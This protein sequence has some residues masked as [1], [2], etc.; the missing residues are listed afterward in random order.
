MD[1]NRAVISPNLRRWLYRGK[2]PGSIAKFVNRAWAAVVSSGVAGDLYVTLEVAG[3]KSGKIVSLPLVV[4]V[5][6]GQRYL[7]SMLG[8]DVQW[9]KNVRAASG[10]V[11]L[12]H[13]RREAV[14]LEDV[15]VEARAPIIK[16]YLQRA[17]GAQPHIPVSKDAPLA[18]FEKI[19]AAYPVFRVIAVS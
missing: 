18:E 13:G 12:H 19:A 2:R 11:V 3:H 16:A 6:N 5:V 9:V 8:E 1:N 17:P 10:K 15:A 7:V 4:G 14:Q